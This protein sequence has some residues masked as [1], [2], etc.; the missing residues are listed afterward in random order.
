MDYWYTGERERASRLIQSEEVDSM[1][2]SRD[3]ERLRVLIVGRDEAYGHFHSILTANIQRWGY[4]AVLLPALAVDDTGSWQG[5]EGDILLYDMDVSRQPMVVLGEMGSG[6]VSSPGIAQVSLRSV[7]PRVRL[8]IALS[9][10]SVSRLSLEQM[11][12][13][14]LLHKPFDMRHLERYLRVFQRLLYTETEPGERV[15]T[16]PGRTGSI[17][18][19]LADEPGA[20]NADS[21]ARG[22]HARILVA[23]DR[24]EVTK[25]VRQC[26]ME[27][28]NQRYH[29][30]VR[31]AH[32]GLELLEQCL[33][34]RPHCVV[35]DLLMP[36]LN[37]YQVMRCLAD[38]AVRPS[39]AFVVISALMQHE[40]PVSR[41]YLQDQVVLY[42]DK[43]FDVENLLAVIERALAQ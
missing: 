9:S 7:W 15:A 26:L 20:E 41:S 8:S 1:P 33:I 22:V 42:V 13:I 11:G 16:L 38:S 2:T 6:I 10:R 35:T 43:P 19:L 23:D 29:Y 36:W 3:R 25:A 12:A 30:E 40:I 24:R 37:G 21:P 34:W 27:Q 14:A 39:P 4:E 32:D 17:R 5:V 31:E 18:L 28:E